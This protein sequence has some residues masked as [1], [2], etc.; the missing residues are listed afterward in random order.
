MAVTRATVPPELHDRY[1]LKPR[2]P[3]FLISIWSLAILVFGLL[4]LQINSGKQSDIETRLI[5]WDAKSPTSVEI[6]WTVYQSDN[7]PVVCVLKAQ[8]ANQF[9]V[10]FALFRAKNTGQVAQYTHTLQTWKNSY[11]VLNP[12]C[13]IDESRLLGT[14]FQPGLLPPAQNAPLFAP[15][16]WNS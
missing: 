10:G 15:W 2:N 4:F 9:D 11:A 12:V 3:I 13:E 1:G 5:S 6:S 7:Q 8:D 14:H 16:Q